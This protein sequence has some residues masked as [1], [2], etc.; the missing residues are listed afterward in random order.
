VGLGLLG[1]ALLLVAPSLVVPGVA[2][3]CVVLAVLLHPPVAAYVLLGLTPLIAGIDRGTLLPVLRPNE[4]LLLLVAVPLVVRALAAMSS[5]AGSHI[6]VTALDWGLLAIAVCSSVTPLSWMVLRRRNISADDVLYAFTLWK[7]LA[8]YVVIRASVRTQAQVRLCLW[9]S[10]AAASVVAVAGILQALQLFGVPQLLATYFAPFGDEGALEI[11]R[12]TSTLAS[13][14]AM[15]DVMTFNLAISAGWLARGGRPRG[16]LIALSALFVM[17]AVGSG[18][19]SGVLGLVVGLLAI[20]WLTR[21][22]TR[23]AA[24][25]VPSLIVTG[26]LMQPVLQARLSGFSTSRG[27]PSSWVSRLDNLRRFFWPE[28]FSD[29]NWLLG[30]RPS[31]RVPAPHAEWWHDWIWIESGHTWLLWNGGIPLFVAFL[32]FTAAALRQTAR[33]ARRRRD[34]VGVAA[35]AAFTAVAVT[36][37][38]TTFDPHLTLRGTADL[39]FALLAL[40][41]VDRAGGQ[42]AAARPRASLVS[43]GRSG[44]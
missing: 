30:V 6:R 10:M 35:I 32:F 2:A 38:L 5:G 40:A 1:A 16:A 23:G 13:S 22:I 7:Y 18:Q 37:V 25:A 21:T 17:G 15:A 4:A 20:G 31:A 8:L 44:P 26:A 28:L 29:F 12:G 19:F 3:A 24:V 9:V 43:A 36:F 33:V 34:A 11:S 42:G 14:F 27:L 41:C 39:L